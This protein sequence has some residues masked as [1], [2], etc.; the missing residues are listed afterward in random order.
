MLMAGGVLRKG[1]GVKQADRN[2]RVC[3]SQKTQLKKAEVENPGVPVRH[4]I[5]RLNEKR[6]EGT[7]RTGH[8]RPRVYID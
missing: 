7:K 5:S 8:T 1:E 6:R 4:E 3:Y 2:E